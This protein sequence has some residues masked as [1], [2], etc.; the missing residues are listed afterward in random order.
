MDEKREL[1]I[2]LHSQARKNFKRRR[3]IMKGID[4]LWQAD[5]V[6]MGNY[7]TYNKGFKYLLT[8]IDTFSKFAWIRPLKS[9]TAIDVTNAMN[10]IFNLG[11]RPKNLQTD[12]GKEFFNN[13]FKNLMTKYKINHYS[14][15]S[16]MKASIVERFN[17][18]LKGMMWKEF[19]YNGSY[20]WVDL[21]E[22]LISDYNKKIHRVIKM[23]PIDVKPSNEKLL[24]NTVYNHIKIFKKNKFNIG[25]NVRISKY[26]HCFEKGYTPN[27]TTEIFKIKHIKITYP[28]TYILEDYMGNPIKGGFYEEELL[29]T[30]Y[31]NTY[32][33]EKV[34]RIKN[35][36]AFVKWL[37]FTNDHNSWIN[38]N[39]IL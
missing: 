3:V 36:R 37:G 38:K 8:V 12:D 11:R 21:Y 28:T 32:L 27:W 29:S 6:E 9:K 18:T 4:D 10:D 39:E 15:Y 34:I 7:S 22:K 24:L 2:E 19:S 5:L 14:T 31:P 33:V 20:H 25:D 13:L 16:I 17:R 26:K 23:A 30:R 1:V 35:N